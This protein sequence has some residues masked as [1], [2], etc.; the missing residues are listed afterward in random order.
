M[1]S[2]CV[3]SCLAGSLGIFGSVHPNRMVGPPVCSDFDD[4]L[5]VAALADCPTFHGR[6][7]VDAGRI[8][9]HGRIAVRSW[10]NLCGAGGQRD[11][12]SP[13]SPKGLSPARGRP[14]PLS[15]APPHQPGFP[16]CGGFAVHPGLS[17]HVCRVESDLQ[18]LARVPVTD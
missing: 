17:H 18:N 14:V 12:L 15:S 4:S 16:L 9:R 2:T 10:A 1:A 6:D 11:G 5:V 13:T 3:V 8:G 7:R